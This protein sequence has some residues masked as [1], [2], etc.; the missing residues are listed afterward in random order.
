MAAVLAV[1]HVLLIGPQV[2]A[3]YEDGPGPSR[4]ARAARA[5]R[6]CHHP[7]TWNGVQG[8]GPMVALGIGMVSYE[9]GTPVG[10]AFL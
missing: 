5:G 2:S 6:V 4:A 3:R 10:P 7:T 1:L 8:S 9:Q